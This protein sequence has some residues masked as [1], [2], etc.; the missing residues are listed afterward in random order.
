MRCTVSSPFRAT[1]R[2]VP[3]LSNAN[4]TAVL[5]AGA[6]AW[7]L[8]PSVDQSVTTLPAALARISPSGEKLSACV[9]VGAGFQRLISLPLAPSHNAM[10]LS[11][12]DVANTFECG[13]QARPNVPNM[14]SPN[15]STAS[16]SP[17][18]RASATLP[19]PPAIAN[20]LLSGAQTQLAT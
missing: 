12:P 1:P 19:S 2:S 5:A 4:A 16:D 3:G 10:T 7:I 20:D 15:T 14:C 11:W 8:S 18:V 6:N 9:G 17:W 13:R